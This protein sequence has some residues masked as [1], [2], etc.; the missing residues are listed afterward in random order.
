MRPGYIAKNAPFLHNNGSNLDFWKTA[1]DNKKHM[2][3]DTGNFV[4]HVWCK[5][6]FYIFFVLCTFFVKLTVF[7]IF[8]LFWVF[9]SFCLNWNKTIM[10][11]DTLNLIT[12]SIMEITFY[13]SFISGTFLIWLTVYEILIFFWKMAVENTQ[14]PCT[15]GLL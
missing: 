4:E 11:V 1:S 2:V 5:I 12:H 7:E 8:G 13:I 15:T 10:A 9:A 14:D 6:K 3:E